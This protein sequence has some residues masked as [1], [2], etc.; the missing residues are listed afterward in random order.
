MEDIE[1]LHEEMDYWPPFSQ[2]FMLIMRAMSGLQGICKHVDP[3]F[4]LGV[5]IPKIPA[6]WKS[7]GESTRHQL[8]I[9]GEVDKGNANRF[10]AVGLTALLV[11]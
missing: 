3:S 7:N 6:F 4:K 11:A 8:Q 2:D 5:H 9:M 1:A 10:L